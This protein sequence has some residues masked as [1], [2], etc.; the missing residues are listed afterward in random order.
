MLT[1]LLCHILSYISRQ[2]RLYWISLATGQ[3][4]YREENHTTNTSIPRA[5]GAEAALWK[6]NFILPTY[7]SAGISSLGAAT[8]HDRLNPEEQ[9]YSRAL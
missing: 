7:R 1:V 2:L 3:S 6:P 5:V 8:E 4:R 9:M